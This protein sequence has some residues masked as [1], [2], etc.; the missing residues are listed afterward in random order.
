MSDHLSLR[1]EKHYH[2]TDKHLRRDRI[3]HIWCP[4]CGLG[5]A[6]SSYTKA[7]EQIETRTGL[8]HKQQVMVSGIGCSG[9]MASYVN[10]DSYHTTHG[11]AV[12]FAT[13]I[14]LAQP[15]LEVTVFSGDGDLFS[16]GGNHII[17]AARRNLDI[18]IFCVNNFIYGMTGG[19]M[20]PTTPHQARSTTSPIGNFEYPFNLPFVMA[21]L[22]ATF[23]SR[24]T[25]SHPHQLTKAMTRAM[26]HKGL[27]FIEIISP[28]PAGF[29]KRNDFPDG[30]SEMRYFKEHSRVDHRADLQTVEIDPTNGKE[31]IVGNFVDLEKPSYLDV[32]N[33]LLEGLGV[34][35]NMEAVRGTGNGKTGGGVG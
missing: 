21:A 32:K 5:V 4:G 29:G 7:V 8:S 33:S 6:A 12:A 15:G 18:N 1:L 30:L 13:G 34:S 17:H 16:I 35:R 3:P 19:Q 14:K 10:I 2:P 26:E 25:T 31:I 28:C 20:A 9:R 24:W 11:R 22:G 27:S 23:V